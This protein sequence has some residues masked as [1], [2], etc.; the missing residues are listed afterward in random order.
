MRKTALIS[1][2]AIFA[3][4]IVSASFA[5]ELSVPT[6]TVNVPAG[7][8]R[9]VT[10]NI[11]SS[12]AD[13]LVLSFSDAKPWVST[14]IQ[15]IVINRSETKGIKVFISP[16]SAVQSGLYKVGILIESILTHEIKS[17]DIFINVE[18][19]EKV[20]IESILISGKLEPAGYGDIK[21]YLKNFKSSTVQ[22]IAFRMTVFSPNE[23]VLDYTETIASIDPMEAKTVGKTVYFDN[24]TEAGTYTVNVMI[25]YLDKKEELQQTFDVM[26]KSV[27]TRTY[28]K[29][30]LLLGYGKTIK[31]RNDGNEIGNETVIEDISSFDAV[32]FSG[33]PSFIIGNKYFWV[34]NNIRPGGEM[35]ISY[36]VDYMP[37]FV[38]ILAVIIACWYFFYKYRTLRIRK[39]IMQRKLI[40][41]GEEFTVGIELHNG[42]GRGMKELVIRDFVPPLFAL[43]YGSGPEPKKKS[44]N[45]GTELV[46]K[47]TDL[48]RGEERILSYKII[49]VLGVHGLISLPAACAEFTFNK[50]NVKNT[51]NITHLGI[52]E[53]EPEKEKRFSIIRKKE[54]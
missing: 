38:F 40:K 27:I 49:P 43:K 8:T 15:H 21:A 7:G 44:T 45:I 42:L 22:D 29:F 54:R 48:K 20:Y 6:E 11:T 47:L 24:V 46:W 33:N 18:R 52:K 16:S 4:M 34:I 36:Y 32:F 14:D 2:V 37:L 26:E 51:S 9:E 41:E 35:T 10:V 3:L 30:S 25:S 12:K 50:M 31:V 19:G 13:D 5:F 39:F 28:E 23:K 53:T 1:M 17:K